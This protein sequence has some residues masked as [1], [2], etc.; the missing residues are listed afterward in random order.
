[1]SAQVC[2]GQEYQRKLHP[3][4][5]PLRA[6]LQRTQKGEACHFLVRRNPHYPRRKQILAPIIETTSSCHSLLS[7]AP[8]LGASSSSSISSALPPHTTKIAAPETT[9]D[10]V[11]KMCKNHFRSCEFCHKN[12]QQ[13]PYKRTSYLPSAQHS[14]HSTN[15]SLS[16]HSICGSIGRPAGTGG[17][18][19][20]VET[21]NPVYNVREI[22]TA[23]HSF[24]SLGVD[25]KLLDMQ[26]HG[27]GDHNSGNNN[28]RNGK[29]NNNTGETTTAESTTV[30]LMG[31]SAVG[32]TS[33]TAAAATTATI[34]RGSVVMEAVH[35]DPANGYGKFVYI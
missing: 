33:T 23:C 34:N 35:N 10:A 8:S 17:A 14:Q 20:V 32:A 29:T 22:R 24:S 25:K 1:M 6:Q 18:F 31:A 2:P 13:Q 30:A 21:Y 19:S 15:D 7:L 9:G 26:L 27:G 11:C 28:K 12:A 5:Q 4:D 3:D 16:R